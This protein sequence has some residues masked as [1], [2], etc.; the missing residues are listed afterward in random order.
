MNNSEQLLSVPEGR[1]I[2]PIFEDVPQPEHAWQIKEQGATTVLACITE[3]DIQ[4]RSREK[5]WVET[6]QAAH[7]AG[8][9]VMAD[10]WGVAHI[11]GGEAPSTLPLSH[12]HPSN[13][14]V[15]K[16]INKG[17]SFARLLGASHMFWDEVNLTN[18]GGSVEEEMPFIKK[19][20][21]K[22]AELSMDNVV[23]LTSTEANMR[24]LR[25]LAADENI[26]GVGTDP[27]Y[28]NY[29]GDN[30]ENP[31]DPELYVGRFARRIHELE[32]EFSVWGHI[33]VQGFH[34]PMWPKERPDMSYEKLLQ[35]AEEREWWNV[36][37]MAARAA[38]HNGVIRSIG[39][40]GSLNWEAEN[41]AD[42]APPHKERV[43]N[44]IH[45]IRQELDAAGVTVA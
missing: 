6:A 11:F 35:L 37:L 36:P 13:P 10:L 42:F 8:L 34:L 39:F 27:Y 32:Q 43:F 14:K 38:I 5:H 19:L 30:Q 18:V 15:W 26:Q 3:A 20:A 16:L 22:A 17:L 29:P 45:L 23:C 44:N 21:A 31:D 1:L 24:K 25:E 4:T 9:E 40:W 33:W 7:E 2:V 12:S 41:T 28:S